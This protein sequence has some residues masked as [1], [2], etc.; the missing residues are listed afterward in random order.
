MGKA[1]QGLFECHTARPRGSPFKVI[2]NVPCPETRCTFI[3]N[4]FFVIVNVLVVRLTETRKRKG[5]TGS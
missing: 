2:I 4:V 1:L 5:Q 3:A